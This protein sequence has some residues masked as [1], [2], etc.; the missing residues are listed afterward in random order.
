MSTEQSFDDDIMPL[1]EETFELTR[2]ALW[3]LGLSKERTGATP[4]DAWLPLLRK[5]A[6]VL[7]EARTAAANQLLPDARRAVKMAQAQTVNPCWE[8]AKKYPEVRRVCVV[9]VALFAVK[10]AIEDLEEESRPPVQPEALKLA[11]TKRVQ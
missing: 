7:E 1:Y 3:T 2:D 11:K 4:A 6:F 5:A 9:D 8:L 10:W